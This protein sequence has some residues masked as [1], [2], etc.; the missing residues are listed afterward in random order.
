[1][2]SLEPD[3]AAAARRPAVDGSCCRLNIWRRHFYVLAKG[4]S[5]GVDR[6]LL[7][8]IPGDSTSARQTAPTVVLHLKEIFARH[9]IPEEMVSD[10]M[11][12][13]SRKMGEIAEEWRI[14]QSTSSPHYAQLNGQAERAIQMVKKILRK[15]NEAGAVPYVVLLQY[16]NT[17]VVDC[18]LWVD[19][20]LVALVDCF[21]IYTHCV[22]IN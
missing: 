5:A 19:S 11:P 21:C 4:L 20:R 8:E 22:P 17:P 18:D 10:N 1:M 16:R 3:V 9:G 15:A 14:S 7:L 2:V 13:S 6:R 12:F